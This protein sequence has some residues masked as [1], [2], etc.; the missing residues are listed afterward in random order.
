MENKRQHSS[1]LIL[2]NEGN[3]KA[4]HTIPITTNPAFA[5]KPP[6]GKFILCKIGEFNYIR[7]N[8]RGA[9]FSI[10]I[11]EYTNYDVKIIDYRGAQLYVV[12]LPKIA[13]IFEINQRDKILI[14]P[15]ICRA[16]KD[17]E[18]YDIVFVGEDGMP[19]FINAKKE[20]AV[21]DFAIK[22]SQFKFAPDI[23]H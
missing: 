17:I 15:V 18:Q 9:I 4:P 2:I 3:K 16:R 10:N 13:F 5:E 14:T 12:N 1:A 22:N 11:G 7:F 23:I 6:N 8:F 19:F 20:K 21:S